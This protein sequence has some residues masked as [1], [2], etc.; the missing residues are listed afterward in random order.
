MK[1]FR[2][3]TEQAIEEIARKRQYALQSGKLH[4]YGRGLPEYTKSERWLLILLGVMTA[5]AIT[6][7]VLGIYSMITL[8][9]N[10]R[11]SGDGHSQGERREAKEIWRFFS[12]QYLAVTVAA[13]AVA[14]PVGIYVMQR[15]LEQYTAGCRWSGGFSR[16]CSSW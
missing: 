16:A 11:R 9:C 14:F 10:Q 7:A 1:D 12:A 13:C 2:E 5:V 4:E 6:I 3:K 15:W 8:G